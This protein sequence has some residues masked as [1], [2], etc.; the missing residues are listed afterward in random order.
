MKN[1]QKSFT[2]ITVSPVV[3]A[4]TSAL[5]ADE[6]LRRRD[7]SIRLERYTDHDSIMWIA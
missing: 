4:H 2:D 1:R 7:V 3:Q 5:L 6:A